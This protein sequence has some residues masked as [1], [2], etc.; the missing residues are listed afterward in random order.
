MSNPA[1]IKEL[2]PILSRIRHLGSLLQSAGLAIE[3]HDFTTKVDRLMEILDGVDSPWVGLNLDTGNLARTADPYKDVAR[4]APY[5]VNAQFK[6]KIPVDGNK[7]EA[8][9][10]RLVGILNDSGYRGYVVLE[11]EEADPKKHIPDYLDKLRK[12]MA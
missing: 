12:A 3:N 10:D 8:D 2:N 4:M 6:V 5:A 1:D 9:F 11:Y 7:E